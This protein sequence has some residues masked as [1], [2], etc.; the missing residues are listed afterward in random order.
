MEKYSFQRGMN[1]VQIGKKQEV[2]DKIMVALNINN[3]ASWYKY[4]YGQLV[5]YII[6]YVAIEGI[7]LEYGIFE[8]IWGTVT[9]IPKQ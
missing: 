3:L 9:K 4:L 2:K 6:V 5:P 1:Q 7:F 8:N